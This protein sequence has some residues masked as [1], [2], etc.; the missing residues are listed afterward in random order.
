M[1]VKRDFPQAYHDFMAYNG[2]DTVVY[3]SEPSLTRQ[4]FADECDINSIM[5]RYNA[6]VVG[7]PGNLPP[8]DPQYIDFTEMPQDL[9]G[10][11]HFMQ[12]TENA[13]MSLPAIVRKEF[14]NDP[15]RFVEYASDPASLDQ[16]RSWGLAPPAKVP[17]PSGEQPPASPGGSNSAPSG[18]PAQSST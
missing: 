8:R 14:D 15:H 18:A 12:E 1:S 4:E 2:S 9:M 13:F 17:E 10:Y 6:H 7:G 5:A 16:M 11:L 3:N